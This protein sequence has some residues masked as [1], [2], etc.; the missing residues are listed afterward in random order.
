MKKAT[1]ARQLA[2]AENAAKL[3]REKLAQ[4][5]RLRLKNEAFAQKKEE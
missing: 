5:E 3:E 4:A 2:N 1:E